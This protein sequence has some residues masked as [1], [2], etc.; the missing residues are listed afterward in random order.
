MKQVVVQEMANSSPL[1]HLSL[2]KMLFTHKQRNERLIWM[3]IQY[4][5]K[6]VHC[7]DD[8]MIIWTHIKETRVFLEAFVIISVTEHSRSHRE[9]NLA[10]SDITQNGKKKFSAGLF[11][12][13]IIYKTCLVA[14]THTVRLTFESKA[15]ECS[16][17]LGWNLGWRCF[18]D[19][20]DMMVLEMVETKSCQDRAYGKK[21]RDWIRCSGFGVRNFH[22]STDN[23]NPF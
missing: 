9:L 18:S 19:P 4:K 10:A 16:A 11:T 14:Q 3:A 15:K 22:L 23:M 1:Q 7:F 12:L 21:I 8:T 2:V 17:Q 5:V 20:L 13:Q 6:S